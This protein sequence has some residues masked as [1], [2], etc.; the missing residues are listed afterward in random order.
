M[1]EDLTAV[2]ELDVAGDPLVIGLNST[3]DPAACGNMTD[4][5]NKARPTFHFKYMVLFEKDNFY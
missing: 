1:M 2:M 5:Y 4:N 3:F